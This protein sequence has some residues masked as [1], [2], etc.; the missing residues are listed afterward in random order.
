VEVP[1][2]SPSLPAAEKVVQVLKHVAKRTW[3]PKCVVLVA[4]GGSSVAGSAMNGIALAAG[5]KVVFPQSSSF[6]M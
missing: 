2:S 3:Q 4:G 5:L 1:T 6:I